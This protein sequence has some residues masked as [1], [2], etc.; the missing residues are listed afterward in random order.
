MR[1]EPIVS[2]ARAYVVPERPSRPEKDDP[3]PPGW[4]AVA[5]YSHIMVVAVTCRRVE[6]EELV[7]AVVRHEALERGRWKL[8]EE[9]LAAGDSCSSEER[10]VL[11]AAGLPVWDRRTAARRRIVAAGYEAGAALAGWDLAFTLSRFA[12]GARCGKS[13]FDRHIVLDFTGSPWD[14]RLEVLPGSDGFLY[15][16][17]RFKGWRGREAWEIGPDGA[18]RACDVYRGDFWDLHHH[19]RMFAPES[20]IDLDD[21]CRLYGVRPPRP[22]GLHIDSVTSDVVSALRDRARALGELAHVMICDWNRIGGPARRVPCPPRTRMRP[23]ETLPGACASPATLVKGALELMGVPRFH[24]TGLLDAVKGRAMASY[25]GGRVECRVPGFELPVRYVDIWKAYSTVGA[26][27]GASAH[28]VARSEEVVPCA[29]EA[30]RL[31]RE[32][33]LEGLRDP[34][35]WRTAG[36][37]FCKVRPRGDLIPTMI[38]V[39]DRHDISTVIAPVWGPPRWVTLLDLLASRLLGGP[40][41]EILDAFRVVPGPPH[42]GLRLVRFGGAVLDPAGDLF[43]Q[44]LREQLRAKIAGERRWA[45]FL[46]TAENS[47]YGIFAEVRETWTGARR[48]R[49]LAGDESF[50][51]R[52]IDHSGRRLRREESPGPY[53]R[54]HLAA[55][56]TAGVRLL[57]AML[58]AH[59]TARGGA[60]VYCDTDSAMA[61][62]SPDGGFVPVRGGPARDDAGRQ[63]IRL[64]TFAELDAVLEWFMPLS[65]VGRPVWDVEPENDPPAG[66]VGTLRFLGYSAKRYAL[67][68][69]LRGG[70]V[71]IAKGSAHALDVLPPEGMSKVEFVRATWEALIRLERGDAKAPWSLPF[72]RDVAVGALPLRSAFVFRRIQQALDGDGSGRLLPFGTL[73]V[74]RASSALVFGFQDIDSLPVAPWAPDVR[75]AQWVLVE[76]AVRARVLTENDADDEAA[77]EI[78]APSIYAG[79][80]GGIIVH[81]KE[82]VD[83]KFQA[84]RGGRPAPGCGVL[85]RRAFRVVRTVPIGKQ[86]YLAS[87]ALAGCIR[88]GRMVE[89]Y[90]N[91]DLHG[92]DLDEDEILR[93]AAKPIPL[94]FLVE[95]TGM[96]RWAL[97]KFKSG[98]TRRLREEHRALL[99]EAVYAWEAQ[100]AG[101]AS[102]REGAAP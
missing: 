90:E 28:L 81:H 92:E 11:R 82:S 64:L 65:P 94:R 37:V 97:Q 42:P 85:A 13:P 71:H 25:C 83:L 3:P 101:N 7:C 72:S 10:Q 5:R 52:L 6:G 53:A 30:R 26:L 102:A 78:G 88:P 21:A 63:G 98:R 49:V 17:Q 8:V 29:E 23:G 45:N 96:S 19:A 62:A 86:T 33:G 18:R 35:L 66:A 12:E 93:A 50:T 24:D 46:K 70:A 84:P 44:L 39:S 22:F 75:R 58:E 61:P 31:V 76:R 2:F 95:K 89:V 43:V 100:K 55:A 79:T 74:P 54:P 47:L 4:R 41:P 91:G 87:E 15:R 69:D 20:D 1:A 73:L 59:V 56:I 68:Y 80:Y 51:V 99:W 36:L 34:A 40:V 57:L 38:Q 14:P 67:F 48:A 77:W 60:V 27:I 9:V 32:V 16:W